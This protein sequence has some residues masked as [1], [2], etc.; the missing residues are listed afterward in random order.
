MA[1]VILLASAKRDL[2]SVLSYISNDLNSPAAAENLLRLFNEKIE[3][4]SDFPELYPEYNSEYNSA[5]NKKYRYRFFPVGNYLVFYYVQ[6]NNAYIR[7][8]IYSKR[9]IEKFL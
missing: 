6:N 9:N 2:G 7:R 3:R 1:T 4:L 5:S 8:I